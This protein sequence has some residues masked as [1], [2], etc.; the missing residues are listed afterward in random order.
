[1][2]DSIKII[3]MFFKWVALTIWNNSQLFILSRVADFRDFRHKT[4]YFIIP[5]SNRFLQILTYD[6]VL[7]FNA[8]R[9]RKEKYGKM[10]KSK[11]HRIALYRTR[12]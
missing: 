5:K 10:R 1:M 2:R 7:K 12:G 11:L 8:S 4:E 6:Q 3:G 9:Q